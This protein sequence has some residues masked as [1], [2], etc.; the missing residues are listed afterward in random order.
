MVV[1][2]PVEKELDYEP[3]EPEVDIK[4]EGSKRE[5]GIHLLLDGTA[6]PPKSQTTIRDFSDLKDRA[7]Y[8]R[9]NNWR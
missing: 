1:E 9:R 7:I 8:Y 5:V 4:E 2:E 3:E 6:R